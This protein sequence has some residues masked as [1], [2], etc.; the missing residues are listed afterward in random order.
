MEYKKSLVLVATII[1]GIGLFACESQQKAERK[2]EWAESMQGLAAEVYALIPFVY[3][4]KAF[5]DRD[6]R[7]VIL[8]RMK[9]LANGSH[10]VNPQMGKKYLGDDPLLQFSLDS[11][12]YDIKRAVSSFEAGHL[13][14]S[15]NTMKSAIGHCF[16][17]HSTTEMGSQAPWTLEGLENLQLSASDKV[18]LLVAGRKYDQAIQGV[19]DYLKNYESMQAQPFEYEAALRKY[20]WLTARLKQRPSDSLDLLQVIA[21]QKEVPG[22]MK[23]QLQAWMKSLQSWSKTV[24][25]TDKMGPNQLI[26]EAR[27]AMKDAKMT[28]EFSRDRGGDVHYLRATGLL[29]EA[30]KRQTITPKD[31]RQAYYLLGISYEHLD[32][33]GGWSLHEVYFERCIREFPGTIEAR[34]CFNRLEASLIFGYSGSR[35]TH[36]PSEEQERLEELKALARPRD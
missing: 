5:D 16:R 29:H 26:A 34:S 14:Y 9:K 27:A 6:N 25:K 31:R 10:Q 17:C 28:Q 15:R 18:D 4:R 12:N 35:G 1:L 33:L 30:L 24:T 20:I 32:D 19:S 8:T 36:L 11:L 22:F 21:E 2:P 3:N 13:D 23:A 7:Y